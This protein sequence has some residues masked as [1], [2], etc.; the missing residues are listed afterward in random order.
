[1]HQDEISLGGRRHIYIFILKIR[2]VSRQR[3]WGVPIPVFYDV[4]DQKEVV[5]K[6]IIERCC[7]LIDQEGL[8]TNSIPILLRLINRYEYHFE[9]C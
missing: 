6:E 8:C 4:V 5:S 9:I 1:M 2:C 3:V 7:Q